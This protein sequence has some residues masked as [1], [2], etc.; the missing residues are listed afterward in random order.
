MAKVYVVTAPDDSAIIAGLR[1]RVRAL[2][3]NASL[4]IQRCPPRWSLDRWG[5][6]GSGLALMRAIKAKLDPRNTL[7][8]GRYVGGI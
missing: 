5:D 2:G 7:N 6:P 8:P 4:V 3:D 1:E